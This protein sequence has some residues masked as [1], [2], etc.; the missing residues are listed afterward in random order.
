MYETMTGTHPFT[1]GDEGSFQIMERIVRGEY[2]PP[3]AVTT[4]LPSGAAD[5]VCRAL[6]GHADDRYQNASE[7]CS[8]IE[9][10]AQEQGLVLTSTELARWLNQVDSIDA[11]AKLSD[12]RAL[13]TAAGT[14]TADTV[15]DGAAN[16]ASIGTALDLWIAAERNTEAGPAQAPPRP[17]PDASITA[18]ESQPP[19]KPNRAARLAAIA[20]GVGAVAVVVAVLTRPD[21]RQSQTAVPDRATPAVESQAAAPQQATPKDGREAVEATP[22]APAPVPN[23]PGEAKS[24]SADGRSADSGAERVEDRP[25]DKRRAATDTDRRRARAERTSK[26]E[27]SARSSSAEKKEVPGDQESSTGDSVREVLDEYARPA[28]DDDLFPP[29]VGKQN[30]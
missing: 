22:T 4:D 16:S 7:L 28:G 15:V 11:S 26:R 29:S 12:S 8:D 13:A 25:K 21:A 1:G 27:P 3:D 2:S 24:I 17:D 23:L 5:I 14:L 30:P 20:V 18:A 9:K 10:L 19:A 6:A